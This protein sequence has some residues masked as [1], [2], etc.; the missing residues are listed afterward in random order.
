MRDLVIFGTGGFARE[1]HQIVEDINQGKS[2]WNFLG[3]L[4]GNPKHH[5]TQVHGYPVLGDTGWL[6]GRSEVAVVVGIGGPAAKRRVVQQIRGEGHSLFGVLVHP[7]AWVGNRVSLG[8]GT[9]VCAGNM[10]TTDIEIRSHVILNLDCTVGHDTMI[11]DYVTVAPSVNI[12]GS[13]KIEEGCD[14]GTNSAVIQ[15]VNIGHW[16]IVGAGAVV[17]KDLPPNV[18]AVGIPAK[19]VKDRPE[20]WHEA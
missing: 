20:G 1:V 2:T 11:D 9:I 3:F 13:V 6:K 10:I 12:S 17:V 14:L 5:N 8:E 7:L 4:D 15:S 18:T 19:R 16:S